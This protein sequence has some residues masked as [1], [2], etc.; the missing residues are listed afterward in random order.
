M[1][2][3]GDCQQRTVLW[4]WSEEICKVSP[5]TA[6]IGAAWSD[7]TSEHVRPPAAF[8]RGFYKPHS[9]GLSVGPNTWDTD[10]QPVGALQKRPHCVNKLLGKAMCFPGPLSMCL[11]SI[12]SKCWKMGLW[13]TAAANHTHQRHQGSAS[14]SERS[15]TSARCGGA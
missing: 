6:P 13:W 15:E 1:T 14:P 8:V 11:S 12:H 9:L 2:R 3:R 4:L 5:S 10:C 7:C